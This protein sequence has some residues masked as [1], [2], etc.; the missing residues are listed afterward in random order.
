MTAP[1]ID[2]ARLFPANIH[3]RTA[4]KVDLIVETNMTPD[5]VAEFGQIA[6]SRGIQGIWACDYFAHRDPFLRR[7]SP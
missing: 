5:A 2:S 6:E 1:I 7:D 3:R 4:L